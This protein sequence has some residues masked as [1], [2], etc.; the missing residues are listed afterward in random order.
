MKAILLY[1]LSGFAAIGVVNLA[2]G[3]SLLPALPG[4]LL[5]TLFYVLLRPLMQALLLPAN[6]LLLG[7]ATP[8]ADALLV[9]WACA[10]SG[11]ALPGYWTCLLCALFISLA[12]WPYSSWRGKRL[13]ETAARP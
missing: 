6:L 3:G 9:L 7:L 2:A 4:A 5:L 1:F 13:L 8:F 10:W 12:Y 11:G